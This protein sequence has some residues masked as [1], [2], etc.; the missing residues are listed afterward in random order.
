MKFEV[1]VLFISNNTISLQYFFLTVSFIT[2]Y[3]LFLLHYMFSSLFLLQFHAMIQFPY[4]VSA[5]QFLSLRYTCCFYYIT[6][7]RVCFCYYAFIAGFVA[8][9]FMHFL[10]LLKFYKRKMSLWLLMEAKAE[11]IHHIEIKSASLFCIV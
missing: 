3:V 11:P 10:F 1:S 7:F 9:D 4:N 2:M 6:Y 8:E 5:Y